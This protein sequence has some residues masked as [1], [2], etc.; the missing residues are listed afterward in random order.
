M[1]KLNGRG[2]QE[3]GPRTGRGLG[4]QSNAVESKTES[5][6]I[7][8]NYL[9][10]NMRSD[11][12]TLLGEMLTIVDASISDQQQR[13]AIKDLVNDKF[14]KDNH[15]ENFTRELLLDF[16]KKYCNN[17]GMINKDEEDAFIGRIG[18]SRYPSTSPKLF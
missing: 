3:K 5:L 15:L 16:S 13:K 14:Y 1:S 9:L 10:D 7:L 12:K 11:R 4:N 2:P 6:F 8:R 18:I 17:D